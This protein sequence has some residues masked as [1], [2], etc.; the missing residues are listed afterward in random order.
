PAPRH[1][2]RRPERLPELTELAALPELARLP[3]LTGLRELTGLTG[4]PQDLP[5]LVAQR[6]DALG[7]DSGA[8]LHQP[9]V[10]LADGRVTR[11]CALARRATAPG[12]LARS[13][14]VL[15]VWRRDDRVAG[16][17]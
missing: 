13:L 9:V 8:L 2:P 3:D 4:E 6:H 15:R 7:G 16:V 1:Q 11:V 5:R 12:L 14:E 17:S 10:E